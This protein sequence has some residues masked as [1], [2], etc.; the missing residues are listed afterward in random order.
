M[1]L[2]DLYLVTRH[3]SYLPRVLTSSAPTDKEFRAAHS[4]MNYIEDEKVTLK[5]LL[6]EATFGNGW[7]K[8]TRAQIF[9][10]G[11]YNNSNEEWFFVNGVATN[12]DLAMRNAI[13]LSEIFQKTITVVH[14]PTHGLV[15]DLVECVFERTFDNDCAVTKDLYTE[16][17]VALTK[18]TKVKVIGHSQGGIIVSRL[19]RLLKTAE[20]IVAPDFFTNLEVYTFASA[21]DEDVKLPGTYQEHF[22]NTDD[23]VARIGMINVNPKSGKLYL[24]KEIGHL[25][26]RDYLE[27]FA[28]GH[29]CGK[30]SKLYRMLGGRS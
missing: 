12:K 21:A 29:F 25:L 9:N 5:A 16:V 27:H 10:I 15:P 11:T 6:R 19:L 2:R 13:C 1:V 7:D 18:G 30:K 28:G 23:F 3:S 14:N 22:A 4:E 26:N 20:S 17:Y 24:R 8:T